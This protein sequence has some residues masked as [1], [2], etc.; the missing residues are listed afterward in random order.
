VA[1][2]QLVERQQPLTVLALTSAQSTVHVSPD[3]VTELLEDSP[4]DVP[5]RVD[6]APSGT[7]GVDAF[8]VV[9]CAEGSAH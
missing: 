9:E 2:E 7:T 3:G 5:K 8:E 6:R 4:V 1:D